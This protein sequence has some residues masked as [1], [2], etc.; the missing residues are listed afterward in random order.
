MATA[1]STTITP[2]I[3]ELAAK[4]REQLLSTVATG[5]SLTVEAAQNWVKAV[6]A[7]PFPELPVVPGLPVTTV[8]TATTYAF[9]LASDLLKAQRDFTVELA[10]VF[11]PAAV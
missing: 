3:A 5:Q 1:K 8:E 11:A 9:D 4:A 10:K 6:S 7:L 2:D